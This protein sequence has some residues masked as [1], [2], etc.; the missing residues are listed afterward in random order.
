MS[1]WGGLGQQGHLA[2]LLAAF[3]SPGDLRVALK[4]NKPCQEDLGRQPRTQ[5][6]LALTTHFYD[7]PRPQDP[8]VPAWLPK[9]KRCSGSVCSKDTPDGKTLRT[10]TVLVVGWFT[11]NKGAIRVPLGSCRV[12]LVWKSSDLTSEAQPGLER[13][14]SR[15]WSMGSRALQFPQTSM[16]THLPDRACG[17]HFNRPY[18]GRPGRGIILLL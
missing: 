11:E 5:F 15:S 10:L 9:K 18:A 17:P 2:A 1:S 3:P 16:H 6:S 12:S 8:S 13:L 14:C 4:M 7:Q